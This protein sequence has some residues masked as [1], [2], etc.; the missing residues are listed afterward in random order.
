[1]TCLAL[2]RH[3]DQPA[4]RADLRK[5]DRLVEEHADHLDIGA[6]MKRWGRN[7]VSPARRQSHRQ[8]ELIREV[9][10]DRCVGCKIVARRVGGWLRASKELVVPAGFEPATWSLAMM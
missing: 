1:M 5:R 6:R 9:A 2:R 4:V 8:N 3:R 7:N 10:A